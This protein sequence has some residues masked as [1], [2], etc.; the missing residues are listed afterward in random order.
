M[1]STRYLSSSIFRDLQ[2]V[3]SF[4]LLLSH[5]FRIFSSIFWWIDL[6]SVDI[7]QI[8]GFLMISH[9]IYRFSSGLWWRLLGNSRNFEIFCIT[10]GSLDKNIFALRTIVKLDVNVARKKIT[11]ALHRTF[12]AGLDASFRAQ[13][14]VSCPCLCAARMPPGQVD[15]WI[16]QFELRRKAETAGKRHSEKVRT[17]YGYFSW[18]SGC[19]YWCSWV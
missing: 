17:S 16:K 9:R 4:T 18:C 2:D 19:L 11:S 13:G 8:F 1:N 12:K 3:H 6:F 7:S 10:L 5:K 15:H 14:I